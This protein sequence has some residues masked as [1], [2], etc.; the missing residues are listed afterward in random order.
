[1]ILINST[2]GK[3][4]KYGGEFS[5]DVLTYKALYGV[6]SSSG[7]RISFTVPTGKLCIIQGIQ[8]MFFPS[9]FPNDVL[10]IDGSVDILNTDLTTEKIDDWS[11]ECPIMCDNLVIGPIEEHYVKSGGLLEMN[12]DVVVTTGSIL[13]IYKIPIMLISE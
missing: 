10:I 6:G 2:Q 11:Y 4:P 13:V 3:N 5:Q 8:C 12:E 1:M 7:V 9:S